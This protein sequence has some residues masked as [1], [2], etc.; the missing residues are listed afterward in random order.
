[1]S[2]KPL[3]LDQATLAPELMKPVQENSPLSD[4]NTASGDETSSAA[5]SSAPGGSSSLPSSFPEFDES[6]KGDIEK[7]LAD[8]K[9]KGSDKLS[10]SAQIAQVVSSSCSVETFNPLTAWGLVAALQKLLQDSGKAAG[11]G[12]E[13]ALKVLD[14]LCK[15]DARSTPTFVAFCAANM[16]LFFDL[17]S[18]KVR[19]VQLAAEALLKTVSKTLNANA[20]P[21]LVI[22]NILAACHSSKNWQTKQGA[23]TFL[24]SLATGTAEVA[25]Q[26]TVSLPIIVPILSE[27]VHDVKPQ[28]AEAAKTCLSDCLSV[29]GNKDITPFVPALASCIVNPQET[30]DCIHKL[31]ATTFVAEVRAPTLSV[32]VP[33]LKRALREG[34]TA[35]RRKAA[36]IIDNMSKL[37]EEPL[38][39]AP[40]LPELMPE[41]AKASDAIADPE[42]RQVCSRA[43][44]GMKKIQHAIEQLGAAAET[45]PLSAEELEPTVRE[46]LHAVLNLYPKLAATLDAP[47]VAYAL[48]FAAAVSANVTQ[49]AVERLNRPPAEEEGAAKAVSTAHA[50]K[51]GVTPV[52]AGFL[53]FYP[54]VRKSYHLS[55]ASLCEKLATTRATL[56]QKESEVDPDEGEELANCQFT[57]AYGA[58][59][60]LNM[61]HM[62]LTRGQRYGLCGPNGCGKS[63]LMRA[64]ANGQVEGFPDASQVRTC[65]VEHDI[66]GDDTEIGVAEY[67]LKNEAVRAV[68]GDNREAVEQALS[69]V[70]FTKEMQA[71]PISSLSGGWKMKLALARAMLIKADILLLDE[72]TNH[73]DVKNVA[74]LENWLCSQKNV[75]AMMV[76]HDSGFLDKVCT[77]IIHYESRKLKTYKGNLAALVKAVPEAK[78]Y[79]ELTASATA[80]VQK[81]GFPEPGILDGVKTKDKAILKMHGVSFTYPNTTKQILNGVSLF[82]SLASRVAVVGPN[83][84]GKSTLIKCLTGEMEPT[85]G[86]VWKHPNLRIAYVAQH[87][88]HHIENHLDWTPAEYIM[89]RYATGEDREA[90]R[91]VDRQAAEKE[92]EELAAKVHVIDGQKLKVERI[93]GRRKGKKGYEYE[94]H[95]QGK[96]PTPDETTWLD[97]D[98]LEKMGFGKVLIEIDQKEAAAAG[99]WLKPLTSANV[100]KHLADVGLENEFALHSQMRGLSG[101]QKVK[102]VLGA[103]T[104]QNPHIVVMDEPTNYLDRDSLAALA[105]AIKEFQGGVV[106]ISHH[107]E[108]LDALCSETWKMDSGKLEVVGGDQNKYAK[109]K[110]ELKAQDEMVDGAGNTIKVKGPEKK[111]SRKEE[112]QKQRMKKL[113]KKNGESLDDDDY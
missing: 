38:E 72:P 50:L 28:V 108:F 36:V 33:L 5:S 69:D 61:A 101:G 14:E 64:I 81:F 48:K 98:T 77:H 21:H 56:G 51:L 113:A 71:A 6:R 79:Y 25:A 52:L 37:V 100:A 95:W 7:L 82:V 94:I 88:F 24:S 68:N 26:V 10:I 97:R 111:L 62:R 99:L 30:A 73:L 80:F 22:P 11:D 13:G 76:S 105:E 47:E 35:I 93:M 20:L 78:S 12:R 65:F 29:V 60:L 67:V 3:D 17:L 1:M 15:Q 87:A 32:T 18:D 66:Q 46:A 63:T 55:L 75:T 58:K 45:R 8:V 74:W 89:W 4:N 102:V 40:F 85:S 31:G 70:G 59:I 44:A 104:W 49:T 34:T 27:I 110:V 92:A 57:L 16:P 53:P 103:A 83:G 107:Q 23:L 54:A 84:A 43:D 86:N 9:A 91:K 41:L 112:K 109:E 19:P 39:A 42:V 96:A 106:L 90:L 2:V